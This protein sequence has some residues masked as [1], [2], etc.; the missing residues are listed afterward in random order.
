MSGVELPIGGDDLAF[1]QAE[2]D[3][4][5]HHDV[6]RLVHDRVTHALSKVT[7]AILSRDRLVEA[8]QVTV[9]AALF[10]LLQ[11]ATETGIVGVAID[12]GRDLQKQ[13]AG[14]VVAGSPSSAI[15]VCTQ[16]A[17]KTEIQGGAN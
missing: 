13:E 3:E 16:V 2:I 15:S 11:I 1:D 5:L 8:G 14:G 4:Q 7:E 10:G 12:F 9:A 6:H 17:G